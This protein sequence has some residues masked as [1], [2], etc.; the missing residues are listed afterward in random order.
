MQTGEGGRGQRS[1]INRCPG[2]GVGGEF[3]GKEELEME[4]ELPLQKGTDKRQ[5][6]EPNQSIG[7]EEEGE[8]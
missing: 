3:L 5:E 8:R 7:D 1:L 4:E 6:V 2:W